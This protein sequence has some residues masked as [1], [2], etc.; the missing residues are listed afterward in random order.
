MLPVPYRYLLCHVL[1]MWITDNRKHH[2][3]LC[4]AWKRPCLESH[5]TQVL[6]ASLLRVLWL[7][8]IACWQSRRSVLKSPSYVL[9][10]V[11]SSLAGKIRMLASGTISERLPKWYRMIGSGGSEAAHVAVT[12]LPGQVDASHEGMVWGPPVPSPYASS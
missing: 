9:V 12:T 1:L 11:F 10:A 5:L 2:C 3:C 8:T 6:T 4:I 7:W